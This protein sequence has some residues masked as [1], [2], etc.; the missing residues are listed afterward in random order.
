MADAEFPAPR[1]GPSWERL[2]LRF[3]CSMVAALLQVVVFWD[4]FLGALPFL[5][6]PREP[7]TQWLSFL[8]LSLCSFVVVSGLVGTLLADWLYDRYVENDA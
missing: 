1:P 5:W 7:T 8:M 2:R 6:P 4:F 3:A